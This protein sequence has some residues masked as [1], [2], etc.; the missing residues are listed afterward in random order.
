MKAEIITIGDEILIGQIVDTNSAWIS[1]QLNMHGIDAYQITSI[2]DDHGQILKAL[3][4]AESRADLILITGGLGPTKDD[5]TKKALCAYFECGL[6]INEQVLEQVTGM[7]TRRSIRINQLNKDQALVPEKCTVLPNTTGTAPGMWFEKD[8]VIFVSM[9]GVPFEMQYLMEN[10]VFPRLQG[11][12]KVRTIYHQTVLIH[13]IPESMLAEHIEPWELALPSFIKL[14]YLPSPF[15]IRLRLSAYGEDTDGLKD[16]VAA[17]IE[18][19]KMIVPAANIFGYNQDTLSGVTGKLLRD[20]HA[21]VGVAESCTGGY[22][23]HLIT[24]NPG[25][26]AY[27]K[28]GVIA[29]ANAAKVSVLGVKPETLEA[30]GAVSKEVALEMARGAQKV[31]Q[32]DYAI[33]TTGIAG[34]DGGTPEKPVGMVWIAIA[35]KHHLTTECYNFAGNRERNMIRSAQTAMNMLRQVVIEEGNG[36]PLGRSRKS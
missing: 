12:G 20:F 25:S 13:G 16:E 32:T 18:K 27:F 14:A 31:L 21:T 26:S 19:L 23:A 15:M 24:S 28:G 2:H 30:H 11:K 17:Q 7:L 35:G 29:Y 5:I 3:A 34:P 36:E 6:V 8:H 4:D 33:A 10:E 22:I 1:E 9:P